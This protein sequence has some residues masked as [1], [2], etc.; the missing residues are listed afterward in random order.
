MGRT[1]GFGSKNRK[2]YI[3]QQFLAMFGHGR[4]AIKAHNYLEA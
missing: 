2:K 3:V 4:V 1:G